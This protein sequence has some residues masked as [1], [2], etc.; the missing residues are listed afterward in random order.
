MGSS[1]KAPGIA[2]G[3]LPAEEI[4]ANFAD[5]HPP[6][7]QHQAFVEADR[8]YF[9]HDAPCTTACPTSIDI[10]MFIRQIATENT[11][12]AAETILQQNIMGGMC[13]RVCP[14]ETLCEEVC[15]RMEAEGKPVK[16]G[17]LQR[18]ATDALFQDGKQVF[19]RG[20]ES[21]KRV[22][23]VG[24]GPA[25]L[26]CAHRLA[27]LGHEVTVLEARDKPGGL[28]EYGIAAYKTVDDFAQR[29]VDYILA[30]GGIT[31][32]YG[33]RLGADVTL[34]QLR[35][36]FDA[37]FLGIGLGAVNALGLAEES[38]DGVEDAVAYIAE[39]R[40]AEN[41]AS[42]PVGRRV[43][44]IGGG[45][46]AIDVA[47]QSKRLGA[48]EV[49]IVYRRGKDQM[50]ASEY[51][52]ELAKISGVGIR[53]W[54]QPVRLLAEGGKVTGIELEYTQTGT[55]GRLEPAGESFTL[56]ADMVFKAIGQAFQPDSLEVGGER[57][58]LVKG[59][60]VVDQGRQTTL[61]D[62]WAGGDCVEGGDDLTVAAVED[63]KVAA[64]SIDRNLRNEG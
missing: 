6:L 40:Q 36:D 27:V 24:A 55:D 5:L 20:P 35:D 19:Q 61:D 63:G 54:A 48:E 47:V 4:A 44:V 51:E 8:C 17:L 60:I 3:R 28:N 2:A 25:G 18:Y 58:K 38:L 1:A 11:Q 34:A 26:A 32:N 59:R 56:A 43:V 23:V 53:H 14:T 39:L 10:P 49:T 45:M 64:E 16:I 15:V 29:E 37:V 12:A 41:K 50:K 21:G 33:K 22:A 46:T 13:A 9:C 7:D 57:L 62:V 52:Q 42:L 31:V 30:V